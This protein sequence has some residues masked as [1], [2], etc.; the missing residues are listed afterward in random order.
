V[1]HD[2]LVKLDSRYEQLQ[3]GTDMEQEYESSLYR[4]N[5]RTVYK[6]NGRNV[7]GTIKGVDGYGRLKVEID[8]KL[9]KFN[10]GEIGFLI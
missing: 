10:H 5:V 9:H 8:Q 2:L 6:V 3:L 4:Y 7:S 1:L